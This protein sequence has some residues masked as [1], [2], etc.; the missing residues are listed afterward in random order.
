MSGSVRTLEQGTAVQTG[1]VVLLAD[2][3]CFHLGG[4]TFQRNAHSHYDKNRK[5]RCE[6]RME[7]EQRLLRVGPAVRSLPWKETRISQPLSVKSEQDLCANR[8]FCPQT[9]G[10]CWERHCAAG[11]C[12]ATAVCWFLIGATSRAVRRRRYDST[13]ECVDSPGASTTFISWLNADFWFVLNGMNSPLSCRY[14]D[15]K[16]RSHT[17]FF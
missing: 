9:L 10:R 7:V 8:L 13:A 5:R 11:F 16:L 4:R 6:F 17:W 1:S 3:F 15:I 14:K 2:Y 12:S